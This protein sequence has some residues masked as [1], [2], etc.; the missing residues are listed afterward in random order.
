M[1]AYNYI[2]VKDLNQITSI[3]STDFFIV[4][5]ENGTNL[6]PITYFILRDNNVSFY[7]AFKTVSGQTDLLVAN[8]STELSAISTTIT[9]SIRTV[10]SGMSATVQDS[11]KRIFFTT[12]ILTIPANQTQSQNII[13]NTN[14]VTLSVFDVVAG[15]ITEPFLPA[16]V[17]NLIVPVSSQIALFV[18]LTGRGGFNYDIRANLSTACVSA[19]R[20][21]YRIIKPY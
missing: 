13:F 21:N 2:S 19:T 14:N 3:K 5:N 8:T 12:G 9:N 16:S 10:I 6:L 15:F 7:N 1:S 17:S 11:Y 18:T 20:V 4:E